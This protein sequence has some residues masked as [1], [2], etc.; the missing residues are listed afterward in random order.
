MSDSG[1]RRIYARAPNH[2]GDVL[3]VIPALKRLAE[4]Y[5]DAA[6]DVWCPYIWSSILESAELEAAVIPFRP[7][8]AL[9]KTAAWVRTIGYDAAYLFAPSFSRASVGGGARPPMDG[10]FC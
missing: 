8:R 7:T 1:M 3:M 4:R 6:L 2:L 10:A 5:P 9:W